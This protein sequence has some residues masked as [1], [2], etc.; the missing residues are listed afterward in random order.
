M[1]YW[2]APLF[3]AIAFFYSSVGLGGG[4]AYIAILALSGVSYVAIPMMAL[5]LNLIVSGLSWTTYFRAGHFQMRT[6]LPFA[7][8]SIPMAGLGGLIPLSEKSL[9]LIL[10]AVL[11]LVA[12]RI[13]FSN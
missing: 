4:S 7:L 6:L 3:L 1:M 5:F 2:L 8:T 13:F 10:C 11:F 12:L 9:H